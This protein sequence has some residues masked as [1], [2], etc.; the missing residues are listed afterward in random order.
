MASFIPKKITQ[1][2]SLGEELRQART[3]LKLGIDEVARKIQIRKEYLLALEAE[4]YNLLPSGLYGKNYLKKY[5]SFLKFSSQ[6]INN[7]VKQL[8]FE[9]SNENPFSKKIIDRKHM[10]IF[11]RIFRNILISL[12]VLA[13]FLYLIFYF[14]NIIVPPYLE[15][16]N[17][18]QNLMIRETNISID[19]RTEPG[20]EVFINEEVLL[21]NDDGSFSK[22]INLKKGM[23]TVEI[24]AKKKYSREKV[25]IRQIL[26]E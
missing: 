13:C 15:I 20:A 1:Q 19:G 3:E 8:E 2:E 5:A 18:T 24:N 14:K 23:N 10:L 4:D 16:T 9:Y 12:A 21:I 26:V 25:E 17:P 6:S 7:F 11:P 22:V